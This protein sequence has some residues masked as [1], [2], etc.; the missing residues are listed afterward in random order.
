MFFIQ[1]FDTEWML[2]HAQVS[3]SYVNWG[4]YILYNISGL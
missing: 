1:V 4:K 3:A 2:I